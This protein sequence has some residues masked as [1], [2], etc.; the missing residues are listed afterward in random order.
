MLVPLAGL[1]VMAHAAAAAPCRHAV[2]VEL[3]LVDDGTELMQRI[4]RR[5]L[6]EPSGPGAPAV[7]S[8]VD[9]WRD[10]DPDR[11]TEGPGRHVDVYLRAKDLE[12]LR[13]R[14]AELAKSDPAL[15]PAPD[16][17]FVFEHVMPAPGDK[18]QAPFW[19]SYYVFA[20]PVL[21]DR[22]IVQATPGGDRYTG[23]A[24][25]RTELTAE[26]TRQLAAVTQKNPNRKLAVLLDDE[27]TLAPIISGVVAKL[28][29]PVATPAIATAVAAKLACAK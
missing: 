17:Q 13:R 19:R 16:H 24:Y 4:G 20:K 5:V 2:R 18:D 8:D 25:A 14:L 26:G 7:S 27:V 11:M 15:A 29:I 23:R 10:M 12:P 22:G 9:G 21:D 3:K 1:L 6:L 28:M